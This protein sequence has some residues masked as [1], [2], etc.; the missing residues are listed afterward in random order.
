MKESRYAPIILETIGD[1]S[2][3]IGTLK[4]ACGQGK[5]ITN[6]R[7]P[8]YRLLKEKKIEVSGYDEKCTTF[9]Y[10]CIMLKKVNPNYTNPIYVQ[11]LL[12][13]PIDKNNYFEIQQIFSNLIEDI[14]QIYHKEIRT[15]E[16]ITDKMPLK[17]AIK[18][19]FIKSDGIFRIFTI[20]TDPK[21]KQQWKEIEGNRNSIDRLKDGKGKFEEVKRKLIK[22]TFEDVLKHDHEAE[23]W[24]LKDKF[25]SDLALTDYIARNLPYFGT[26]K[27]LKYEGKYEGRYGKDNFVDGYKDFFSHLPINE[28]DEKLL[29]KHFV[30]GALKEKGEKRDDKLWELA[31]DLTDIHHDTFVEKLRILDIIYD[32]EYDSALE[33]RLQI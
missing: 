15:L 28:R 6:I 18:S 13:N 27:Y 4:K 5:Q 2:A 9:H 1:A 32:N 3:S 25:R 11:G 20:Y 22:R 19:G 8:L 21:T 31:Y 26:K 33:T 30:I 12:D 14:N 16:S 29:F 23:I 17:D 10:D 7:K 24:Y